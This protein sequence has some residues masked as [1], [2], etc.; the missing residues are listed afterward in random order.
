MAVCCYFGFFFMSGYRYRQ[1]RAVLKRLVS[2][3]L[4]FSVKIFFL[5]MTL[6]HFHG[7]R[8]W[9]FKKDHH[10]VLTADSAIR[11]TKYC[12]ASTN[13][14]LYNAHLSTMASFLQQTL[15]WSQRTVQ[16]FTLIFNLSITL[17][18]P[19]W[20]GRHGGLM[21]S[22]LDS[23]ASAPGSSPGRGHTG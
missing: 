1:S 23:G 17:T 2:I 11:R 14:C 20:H 19:Q 16:T 21:V 5:P 4:S 3:T 10:Y 15:L 22:A 12:P 13:V 7:D 6:M 18:S 9:V 8:W